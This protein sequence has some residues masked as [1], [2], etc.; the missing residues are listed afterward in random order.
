MFV[1]IAHPPEAR[2]L[3][4]WPVQ[5]HTFRCVT[6]EIT[7]AVVPAGLLLLCATRLASLVSAC[8]LPLLCCLLLVASQRTRLELAPAPLRLH[9]SQ[10]RQAKAACPCASCSAQQLLL[11]QAVACPGSRVLCRLRLELLARRTP[12]AQNPHHPC[13]QSTERQGTKDNTRGHEI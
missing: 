11:L 13:G 10:P 4:Y 9:T 6:A 1:I 7:N 2:D 8:A 12:K 5:P 3:R